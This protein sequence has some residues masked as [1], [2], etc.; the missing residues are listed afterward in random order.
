MLLVDAD[1]DFSKPFGE[2]KGGSL[3]SWK[4][5]QVSDVLSHYEGC[6]WIPDEEAAAEGMGDFNCQT[7]NRNREPL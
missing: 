4:W 1:G 7:L 3:T 6:K 2:P 5:N